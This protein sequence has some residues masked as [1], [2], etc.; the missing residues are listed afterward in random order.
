MQIFRSID[1]GSAALDGGTRAACAA[2]AAGF[3]VAWV[4]LLPSLPAPTGSL[5]VHWPILISALCLTAACLAAL[6]RLPTPRGPIAVLAGYALALAV[7]GLPLAA[8]WAG[9]PDG[10]NVLL[11]TLQRFDASAYEEGAYRL[12]QMGELDEF[13]ARRPFTVGALGALFAVSGGSAVFAQLVFVWLNATAVFLASRAVAVSHGLAAALP[14]FAALL[15]F[16]HWHIGS[17]LSENL[18]LALGALAF[19]LLWEGVRRDRA[20]LIAAG[21]VP[22]SLGMNARAGAL[23]VLP[24]LVLWLTWRVRRRGSL[25]VAGTLLWT[26]AATASGFVAGAALDRAYGT[27]DGLPFGNFAPTL[28]GVVAGNEGW[29]QVYRDHPEVQDITNSADKYRE[30]YRLALEQAADAPLTALHGVVDTYNDFFINTDWHEF[31]D[32]PVSRSVALILTLVGLWHAWRHRMQPECALLLTIQLGVFLSVPMLADGG[33]RVFAA[34]IPATA[35]LIGIGLVAIL[36]RLG[37]ARQTSEAKTVMAA[38]SLALLLAVGLLIA[39]AVPLYAGRATVAAEP[40]VCE[41][42]HLPI[43]VL[44]RA[45]GSIVV[46]PDDDPRSGERA[47]RRAGAFAADNDTRLTIDVPPPFVL[48]RRWNSALGRMSWLV[49]PGDALPAGPIRGCGRRVAN[50]LLVDQIHPTVTDTP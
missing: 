4:L 36:S 49:I 34:S 28:Y 29:L 30:I 27:E 5:M 19:A 14:C 37:G 46:L 39:P 9:G 17:F 23:F 22:L 21:L 38:P 24:I 32:D 1:T 47:F 2:A 8:M 20:G 25:A 43:S 15:T 7:F 48:T 42:D 35:A 26:L 33:T 16:Y 44:D 31:Y 3:A 6:G 41:G 40:P 45:D 50:V 18:G 12:W 10:D 11:G 13:G